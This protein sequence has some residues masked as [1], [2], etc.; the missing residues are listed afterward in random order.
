[1]ADVT[2]RVQK[3][4]VVPCE[5]CGAK[6]GESCRKGQKQPIAVSYIHA[7]RM[8]AWALH[9]AAP[10]PVPSTS[11]AAPAADRGTLR[12]KL[13][14]VEVEGEGAAELFGRLLGLFLG[15]DDG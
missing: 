14:Q 8:A 13:V 7:K 9:E 1:M 6:V 10:A 4:G 3:Y 5:H 11:P 12:I 2:T 15:R